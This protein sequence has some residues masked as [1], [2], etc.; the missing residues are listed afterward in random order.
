MG[1]DMF[2]KVSRSKYTI[3]GSNVF[4]Q[5]VVASCK[6][7]ESFFGLQHFFGCGCLLEMTIKK[8]GMVINPKSAVFVLSIGCS[9]SLEGYVAANAR[10]H[11]VDG[12]KVTGSYNI[13]SEGSSGTIVRTLFEQTIKACSEKQCLATGKV[14]TQAIELLSCPLLD[15]S[16]VN[17]P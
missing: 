11:L 7:L 1:F 3:V 15:F 16:K 5:N 9:A 6:G 17:V 10:D 13:S 12:N 8:L 14:W 4:D 2:A